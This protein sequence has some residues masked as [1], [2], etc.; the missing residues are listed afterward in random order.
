[1]I[2]G[3]I[4]EFIDLLYYGQEI[5]FIYKDKKY[6]IQGYSIDNYTKATMELMEVTD[7]PF[8]GY[9]WEYHADT[10]RECAEAFLAAP[11]WNGK[12]FMQ[13]QEEVTWSDW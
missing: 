3:D 13:I 12:D 11:I 8:I 2:D 4:N 1:M 6:F 7:Q 5:V 10:M 9:L